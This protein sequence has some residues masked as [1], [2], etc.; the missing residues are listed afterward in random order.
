[1]ADGSKQVSLLM[2]DVDNFKKVNDTHG[3]IAGDAVL[4]DI[5]GTIARDVRGFDLTARY[6][7]EEF[8]VV[9]PDTSVEIA[10]AVAERL[11][12]RIAGSRVSVRGVVPDIAVSVSIGVAQSTGAEDTPAALLGRADG[13]LYQA[14]GQGRNKVVVAEGTLRADADG[15]S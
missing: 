8:V 13:A 14:K 5:A 15:A 10:A 9:M 4:C 3:H 1:M 11:R 12:E 7:G 2:I 6:G